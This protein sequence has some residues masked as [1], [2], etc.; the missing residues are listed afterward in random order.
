MVAFSFLIILFS[1]I[2]TSIVLVALSTILIQE[3]IYRGKPNAPFVPVPSESLSEIARLIKVTNNSVVYDLG[4]GDGKILRTLYE[5]Y[6]VGKFVGIERGFFPYTLS[7]ISHRKI[8]N[9]SFQRKDFFATDLSSATMIVTYLFPKLMDALLPKLE[10][11]LKP[12]TCLYSI[13]FQ[14]KEK[15]PVEK[16]SLLNIRGARGRTVYVYEF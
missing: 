14:F 12:G 9:I 11:Q 13:D 3:F 4:S 1:L 2:F 10:K 16:I 6:K 15:L 8:K 5:E 7:R